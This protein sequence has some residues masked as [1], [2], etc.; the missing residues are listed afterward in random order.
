MAETVR[1]PRI[2][3]AEEAARLRIGFQDD[4]EQARQR[5]LAHHHREVAER[6]GSAGYYDLASTH[7]LEA[8]LADLN[9]RAL[10]VIARG[11]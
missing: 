3:P 10:A 1:R 7:L 6:L 2:I 9:A 8:R 11:T 5:A 4:V